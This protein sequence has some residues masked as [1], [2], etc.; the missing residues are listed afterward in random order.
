MPK[1]L[2]DRWQPESIREF[3]ASARLRFDEGLCLA[4]AGQRTGA[5]YLWGYA[6]EMT[7]KAAYFGLLGRAET[8]VLTWA[9]DI[10]PAIAGGIGLGIK[11][12]SQGKG[13]NVRAWAELLVVRRAATPGAAYAPAFGTRVQNCGQQIGQ[14]WS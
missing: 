12:P 14:L 2:P 9:A 1:R 13:H 8:D 4:A 6:A 11:W 5:I 3:R 7:L 10:S